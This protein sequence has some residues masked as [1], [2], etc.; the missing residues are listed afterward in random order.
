MHVGF[1]WGNLKVKLPVGRPRQRL[2]G[3]NEMD[4]TRNRMGEG[5][6][7]CLAENKDK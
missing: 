6:P 4:F 3:N 1:W 2:E 5:G 7:I